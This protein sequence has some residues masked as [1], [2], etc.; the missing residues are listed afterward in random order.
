MIR[1]IKKTIFFRGD[2]RFFFEITAEI[3]VISKSNSVRDDGDREIRTFQQSLCL[4]DAE[5]AQIFRNSNAEILLT[6]LVKLASADTQS[7]G[8]GMR[9]QRFI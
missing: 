5:S 3:V 4:F 8:N 7:S 2:S 1:M 6:L 9:I